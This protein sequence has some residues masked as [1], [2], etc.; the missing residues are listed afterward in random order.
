[1][2][3][4]AV[5]APAIQGPDVWN[6]QILLQKSVAPMGGRPFHYEWPALIGRR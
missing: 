1:M 5:K 3:D 6:W 4:D 2:D